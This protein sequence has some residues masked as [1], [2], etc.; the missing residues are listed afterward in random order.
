[1][2]TNV[3]TKADLTNID[4]NATCLLNG[5]FSLSTRDLYGQFYF[6][7]KDGRIFVCKQDLDRTYGVHSDRE[8]RIICDL[9]GDMA[10]EAIIYSGGDIAEFITMARTLEKTA[11]NLTSYL[12][13]V[14]PEEI[15]KHKMVDIVS[16]HYPNSG[17][18]GIIIKLVTMGL[19][20]KYG[21]T[22]EQVR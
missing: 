11:Q 22:V 19:E 5:G 9:W 13:G 15:V 10:A 14:T 20:N 21:V 12:D 18:K 1:M 2:T 7:L 16:A 6:A 3:L 17:I 8:G 4:Y